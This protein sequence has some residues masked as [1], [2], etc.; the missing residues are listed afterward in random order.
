MTPATSRT[1]KTDEQD[2][3]TAAA[4]ALA[5]AGLDAVVESVT[6]TPAGRRRVARIALDRAL[7]DAQPGVGADPVRSLDLDE[8]AE[9]TRA[10][11]EAL[12][13]DDVMGEQPYTLEVTTPGT[14]RPLTEPVHYRRNVGRLV[15][16]TTGDGPVL[17]RVVATG[18]D[19]LLIEVAGVKG[20]PARRAEIPFAEITKGAVEVE[21]TRPAAGPDQIDPTPDTEES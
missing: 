19:T 13:R 6:I 12:D 11:G 10:V 18:P 3:H 21:F 20:R 5:A 1:S 9:A 4:A 17:G 7:H 14:D 8:V 16:L 15:S 2:V